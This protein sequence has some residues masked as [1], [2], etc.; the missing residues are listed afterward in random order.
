MTKIEWVQNP[1]G[2]QGKTWNPITGCTKISPGC[3]NC[4]A[5]RMARRLAG[6]CGYPKAPNHFN[7]TLHPDRL[8][9][10]L[11]RKKPTTYFVCS[12]SDLFHED[13]PLDSIH[14]VFAVMALA[15]QHTFQTLTKRPLRMLDVLSNARADVNW[16]VRCELARLGQDPVNITWPLPNVW[17][18]VT[19][20]NQATADE[21]IPL[22]LQTP[23]AV[24]F[25]SCEPLLG[26]MDLHQYLSLYQEAD[27]V[28]V[29]TAIGGRRVPMTRPGFPGWHRHDG[30][31]LDWVVTGGE[32][33]PGARPMHPQWARDIRDQCQTVRIP[34]FFKQW[35]AWVPGAHDR[36]GKMRNHGHFCADGKWINQS[37][38]KDTE[39]FMSRVGK[40]RAGHLLDGQEWR[41][42]PHHESPQG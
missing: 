3:R 34:F 7:V 21:R 15:K 8:D 25:V 10:P 4:Y 19:A 20:E 41:E 39:V 40:K 35:G 29:W 18:G 37:H 6:R 17:L 24:R 31:K 28:T 14:D 2:T 13:V 16:I 27:F 33:G 38:Q 42:F 32:S 11:R 5:E 30:R 9:E 36:T 22:L 12:M 23:S 1:D 26:L